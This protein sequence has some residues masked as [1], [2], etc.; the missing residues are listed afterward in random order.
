MKRRERNYNFLK[1]DDNSLF[2][3]ETRLWNAGM[4]K[5]SR[6]PQRAVQ[7]FLLRSLDILCDFC[8]LIRA[9]NTCICRLNIMIQ[10]VIDLSSIPFT[11]PRTCST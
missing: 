8:A 10:L 4:V 7:L 9:N 6:Q 1:Y 3:P 2:E 11:P 5:I